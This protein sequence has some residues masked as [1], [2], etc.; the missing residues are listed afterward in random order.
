M[1]GLQLPLRKI[2]MA[3]G[4]HLENSYDVND[5]GP[6]WMKFS[7]SMQNVMPIMMQRWKSKPEVE[8]QH[9]GRF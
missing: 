8:F 6:I 5:D 3:Y 1:G 2:N 9:G 4:H 7:V